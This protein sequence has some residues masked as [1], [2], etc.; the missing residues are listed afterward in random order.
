M[1]IQGAVLERIG[2]SPPYAISTPLSVSDLDLDPPGPNELLVRMEAAGICHSD[3]SV[4]DGNR[5]RPLPM[6]LGHEG[7][8]IVEE[9]GALVTDVRVGQRVVMTFLPR[10]GNCAGL[11]HQRRAALPRRKP[12]QRARNPDGRWHP[13]ATQR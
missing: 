9:T 13:P 12:E 7:A 4:V 2:D 10:C 6:L 11:R 8:G 3:L 1:H 5:R